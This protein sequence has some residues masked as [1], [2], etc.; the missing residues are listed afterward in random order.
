M[1][2]FR[3]FFWLNIKSKSTSFS[4]GFFSFADGCQVDSN[5]TTRGCSTVDRAVAYDTRGRGSNPDVSNLKQFF[6]VNY[7][8]IMYKET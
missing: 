8:H 7:K 3:Q 5:A 4:K 1:G 2:I 6:I